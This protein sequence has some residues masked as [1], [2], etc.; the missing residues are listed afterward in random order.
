MRVWG[1]AIDGLALII[2]EYWTKERMQL[3]C[4][5]L[6]LPFVVTAATNDS[7]TCWLN[8][9]M[10]IAFFLWPCILGYL[11][12]NLLITVPQTLIPAQRVGKWSGVG[13]SHILISQINISQLLFHRL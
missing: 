1:N 5:H 2:S 6:G 4:S 9:N 10:K 12:Q 3:A 8:V 7:S 13:L 11:E